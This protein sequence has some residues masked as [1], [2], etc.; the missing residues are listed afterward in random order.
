[1]QPNF[2]SFRSF[3]LFLKKKKRIEYLRVIWGKQID[4]YRNFD[5]ISSYHAMIAHSMDAPFVDPQTWGDLDF[6]AVF[7]QMDRNISGIGQ[8][9]LYHLLHT[10]EDDESV[11]RRRHDLVSVI[12]TTN[13]L[14]ENIQLGLFGLPGISSYFIANLLIR[15][16]LPYTKFYP[17]FYL[18]PILSAASLLLIPVN[19]VFLFAAIGI[20]ITNIIINKIFSNR[21]YDYFAGFSGLNALIVTALHL[22]RIESEHSI[23]G[24]EKLKR[25][26][27]LLVS[28]EKKLG[29]F[30]IDKDTLP[31]IGAI[32][33][34]YLNMLFLFDIVAYYRSVDTLLKY[35]TEMHDVYKTVAE[36]DAAVS[37]ASYLEEIPYYSTP[38]FHETGIRFQAL[39]HPLIPDAVSNSMDHLTDSVLI[40]GSNMSGKTTFMKT[41]GLNVILAR[42]L[43]FCLA[44]SMA[45]PKLYVKSSIRRNENLNEEKSYFFAE[46]ESLHA[47][48][49]LSKALNRYLF[50]I[51][52]IFRGTNTVERLASAT[53][54]LKYL[55]ASNTVFVTTH[56]IELQDLLKNNY[57]MYHFSEQVE[58][59]GFF[60]NF[61][62]Q[63]GPCSS[64]NAVRLLEL[65]GYPESVITEARVLIGDLLHH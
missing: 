16:K 46:I 64:G 59:G 13:V 33:I 51:D 32:V 5:L 39:Y 49:K 31:E 50:L 41:V 52:E 27:D 24:I 14:R 21:I 18:C 8:Q 26:R 6:D 43:H 47:F 48:M 56:D 45:V 9:Y 20:A 53:A 63:E 61:R 37:I 65:M 38:V 23:S 40:T 15:R 58:D 2:I 60:F 30:V 19:G 4:K 12:K 11:L 1:M 17:L 57:R 36:L 54:V 29:Y 7:T 22:S 28:L 62:I 42:T 55:D 35:Q 3:P 10:Y 44:R 25:Y 34:E